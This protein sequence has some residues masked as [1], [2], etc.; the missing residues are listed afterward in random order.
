MNLADFGL[1]PVGSSSSTS[2]ISR[3][4]GRIDLGALGLAPVES[5][6]DVFGRETAIAP[7][8]VPGPSSTVGDWSSG[9][10]G[11]SIPQFNEPL[12]P[13][14]PSAWQQA[15]QNTG[16]QFN[17]DPASPEAAGL[18]PSSPGVWRAP[19]EIQNQD[20]EGLSSQELALID[21]FS[22][23]PEN[24][25]GIEAL[26][27]DEQKEF[28][29][30]LIEDPES[31]RNFA[32]GLREDI[33][34]AAKKRLREFAKKQN[35]VV[36]DHRVRVSDPA[37]LSPSDWIDYNSKLPYPITADLAG[38]PEQFARLKKLNELATGDPYL[39][40]PLE[41]RDSR[42]RE[43]EAERKAMQSAGVNDP[44]QWLIQQDAAQRPAL[45][46]RMAGSLL[47]G[48]KESIGQTYLG[49]KDLMGEM[50]QGSAKALGLPEEPDYLDSGSRWKQVG[51]QQ[52]WDAAVRDEAAKKGVLGQRATRLAETG[53]EAVGRMLPG[54]ALGMAAGSAAA[55]AGAG[56]EATS[57][58]TNAATWAAIAGDVGT[59][60]YMNARANGRPVDQA[61]V[62]GTLAAGIE[63]VTE[64][65]GAK[66]AG[67]F[68][69]TT[70]EEAVG[71]AMTSA[72]A[73]S[74]MELAR[75]LMTG[76]VSEGGEEVAAD[77][78]NA[79][80]ANATGSQA[81]KLSIDGLTDTFLVGAFAAGALHIPRVAQFVIEQAKKPHPETDAQ[82][83]A[84]S[85][86]ALI[87]SNL[88]NFSKL[89]D[90]E[91]TS[92][93][94]LEEFNRRRNEILRGKP[95]GWQTRQEFKARGPSDRPSKV[96]VVSK[97][98]APG[99]QEI[100]RDFYSNPQNAVTWARENPD[101]AAKLAASKNYTPQAFQEADPDLPFF[102]GE[103][104][105]SIRKQFRDVVKEY[106]GD[107]AKRAVYDDWS[108]NGPLKWRKLEGTDAAVHPSVKKFSTAA[109]EFY[110][111]QPPAA[112]PG[113][114]FGKKAEQQTIGFPEDEAKAPE[115][116]PE[117]ASPPPSLPEEQQ[118]PSDD[119]HILLGREFGKSLIEGRG[120]SNINDARKQASEFLG[121]RVKPGTPDAKAVDEAVEA[122]TVIAARKII[123][124][125]AGNRE[126]TYDKL[127]DLY[128]RQPRLAVQ[129]STS[130]TNQA[131]STPAPLAYLAHL[132]ADPSGDHFVYDSSAGNGMLLA[133]TDVSKARANEIDP[134]R[135]SVIASQGI[136]VNVGDAMEHVPADLPDR[137]IINPP[138]GAVMGE[139]RLPKSWTVGTYKTESIDH[140][141]TLKT[142]ESMKDDGKAVI[143]IGSKG[144]QT[145]KPKDDA[146][147][148]FAYSSH[149]GFYDRLYDNYNVVD[150]FTVSGDLYARQGAKFP[151]DVIV[152][153]GKGQSA[154]PK[155]WQFKK[156]GIP[157]LLSSWGE[158]GDHV[159]ARVGAGAEPGS[160]SQRPGKADD[161]GLP[162]PPF[163]KNR[164]PGGGRGGRGGGRPGDNQN[165]VGGKTRG[166]PGDNKPGST[167]G[168]DGG[169]GDNQQPSGDKVSGDGGTGGSRRPGE[170][171]PSDL[172]DDG[173]VDLDSLSEDEIAKKLLELMGGGDA[174]PP[175]LAPPPPPKSPPSKFPPQPPKPPESSP[176]PRKGDKAREELSEAWD[177]FKDAL[178][179][180]GL[181][182]VA[183][184]VPPKLAAASAKLAAKALKA[185]I[186]T[187]SD[188]LEDAVKSLGMATV[189]KVVGPLEQAWQAAGLLTGGKTDKP[190]NATAILDALEKK[191]SQPSEQPAVG[192][193]ETEF[194]VSYVPRS[195]AGVIGTLSPVNQA[196]SIGKALDL[197]I[198][199]VGELDKYVADELGMK[200][201]DV[202]GTEGK[203]GV[204]SAEQVDALALTI[205]NFKRGDATIVADQ[206]GVGKGRVIAGLFAF[207]KRQG[208]IPI[209]VTEK[210]NL[211]AD[212]MR[213]LTDIGLNSKN[214]LFEPLITNEMDSAVARI[215]LH[216][217]AEELGERIY[218]LSGEALYKEFVEGRKT[219]KKNSGQMVG[220]K[221]TYDAIFTT[222]SQ[223]RPV[224]GKLSWRNG[225]IGAMLPHAFLVLDESHN[226]G[227]NAS[228]DA[229]G[230]GTKPREDKS[231]I[232]T[233]DILRGLVARAQG[234]VYSS[235]TFAKRAGMLDLYS[236]AG[237]LDAETLERI[238]SR[239]GVPLQ[240][241]L[242]EMW[243]EAGLL[244]RRE[245]S[246]KGV[247]LKSSVLD[248]DLDAVNKAASIYRAI[249]ALSS[250]VQE[251]LPEIRAGY[252]GEGGD[253]GTDN[254]TGIKGVDS[255]EFSSILHNLNSQFLF[256]LKVDAVADEA[257]ASI[258][259]GESPVIAVDET[260]ETALNRYATKTHASH[261]QKIDFSIK[262][263]F[264]RY[265]ERSR[266]IQ[267]KTDRDGP[268]GPNRVRLTDEELGP[269]GVAAFEAA[270]RLIKEFDAD[271]PASPIDW[272]R[273]R[274][275]KAGYKVAEI[276]GR[277]SMID[278]SGGDK[279]SGT[280]VERPASELGTS[281]K[282][283]SVLG[284]NNGDIDVL[285]L[286]RSGSTGLSIHASVK[287]NNKRKR[288]M[289]IAQPAK[290]IDEFMQMLG[291]VHRTGQVLPPK[292]SLFLTTAPG[293]NRMS[294]VLVRKL[295]SLNAN[296]TASAKGSVGFD[297]P[298]I[299]NE[300][301][302]DVVAD[303]GIA[304]IHLNADMAHPIRFTQGGD[305]ITKDLST[306]LTGRLVFL[307][308]EIQR[309]FWET[310]AD[311]FR[312]RIELLNSQNANPLVAQ[313]L[314]LEA[315][316]RARVEISKGGDASSPNP[317]HQPA[318]LEEVDA[319]RLSK[320]M[321]SKQVREA[322]GEFYGLES[323]DPS[324][325]AKAIEWADREIDDLE[326]KKE[327]WAAKK[328]EAIENDFK[329]EIDAI[330][331]KK[332]NWPE[333]EDKASTKRES[334]I[335]S[336]HGAAEENF[337]A[338]SQ[339]L[340][341]FH[342]GRT[343]T[344][345]Y[346]EQAVPGVV[347]SV[348]RATGD[349]P[350]A[351]GQ[352]TF[353]IAMS[354]VVRTLRVSASQ[355]LRLGLQGQAPVRGS[356]FMGDLDVFDA[357]D[358]QSREKRYIGTGNIVA[359]MD[360]LDGAHGRISFFTDS[361]GE[362]R[363]GIVLP[364][365][366]D[367]KKFAEA[368]PVVFE[369]A[370]DVL[371]F[372]EAGGQ[373][374]T[375]DGKLLILKVGGQLVVRAP[376]SKSR[377]RQ[378][379]A[380]PGIMQAASPDEFTELSQRWELTVGE[381]RRQL[382]VLEAIQEISSIITEG[383]KDIARR[384]GLDK[385]P[386]FSSG[387]ESAMTAKPGASFAKGKSS[388]KAGT[389]VAP[390]PQLPSSQ[391]QS[392]AKKS[393][394]I[395][396]QDIVTTLQR[397]F[398][399]PIRAGF[400]AVKKVKGQ[401]VLGLY[402][403]LYEVARIRESNLFELGTVTHET[404]HHIDN[405]TKTTPRSGAGSM[406]AKIPPSVRAEI[407]ALDYNAPQQMRPH[408]GWAEFIRMYLTDH[409]RVGPVSTQRQGPLPP[410][411]V[412]WFETDWAAAHP[413]E[414]RKLQKAREYIRQ[415][416]DQDVLQ[417][418]SAAIAKPRTD[419]EWAGR[420]AAM[421]DDKK[422]AAMYEGYDDTQ[423][424]KVLDKFADES[425]NTRQNIRDFYRVN[426]ST[427]VANATDA[428]EHGVFDVETGR[429]IGK[430][431]W[432][433]ILKATTDMQDIGNAVAYA[434]ARHTLF[435]EQKRPEYN[436]AFAGGGDAY[437]SVKLA[438]EY[439][440]MLTKDQVQ[441]YDEVADAISDFAH[442]LDA[443]RVRAG[444][445]SA[446]DYSNAIRFY[447]PGGY[448][449]LGRMADSKKLQKL[450]R[451]G[452]IFNA[453]KAFPGRSREGSGRPVRDAFDQLIEQAVVAYQH[454]HNARLARVIVERLDPQFG[455]ANGAGFFLA[456]FPHDTKITQLAVKDVL[457]QLV[458]QGWVSRTTANAAII[459]GMLE[460]KVAG[461][462]GVNS[463]NFI[464]GLLRLP[465]NASDMQIIRAAK[466]AGVPDILSVLRRFRP[467]WSPIPGKR[468]VQYVDRKTGEQKRY[469]ILNERL[470]AVVTGMNSLDFGVFYGALKFSQYLNKWFSLGAIGLSTQ[471]QSRNIVRDLQD[472]AAQSKHYHPPKA[473]A[474]SMEMFWRYLWH[475]LTTSLGSSPS[476]KYAA[477]FELYNSRGG[478]LNSILKQEQ[479]SRI[480]HARRRLARGFREKAL[481][482]IRHPLETLDMLVD[483]PVDFFSISDVP[484]RLSEADAS[485]R[486]AGYEPVAGTTKW[487]NI[488]TGVESPQLPE[489]VIVQ[490]MADALDS[491]MD[492]KRAGRTARAVNALVPLTAASI[493]GT[494]RRI[495]NLAV[496]ASAV[497]KLKR[498]EKLTQV[499]KTQLA[500]YAA[501]A[502]A[503]FAIGLSYG[504]TGGKDDHREEEDAYRKYN[505]LTTGDDGETT[506]AL[507]KSYQFAPFFALGEWLAG[508]MEAK[509]AV[510]QEIQNDLPLGGGW[511]RAVGETFI[512]NW[513][514]FRGRPVEHQTTG[515]KELRYDAY[516]TRAAKAIGNYTGRYLGV[517]PQQV[518]HFLGAA[519]GGA[520]R[521]YAESW[522]AWQEDRLSLRQVPLVSGLYVGQV[523]RRS[524]NEFFAEYSAADDNRKRYN[525][526][527]DVADS[528]GDAKLAEDLREKADGYA[529]RRRELNNY[530]KMIDAIT[531][532]EVEGNR[533]GK[534]TFD[535]QKYVVGLAR[536]AIGKPKLE[537]F[538]SPLDD[539]ELP[540]DLRPV[541]REQVDRH[542]N[543]ALL[544]LGRPT[545]EESRDGRS[546]DDRREDWQ[547]MIEA[548]TDFLRRHKDHPIVQEA[549]RDAQQSSGYKAMRKAAALAES[550]T[551]RKISRWTGK[552]WTKGET[553][554]Q[555]EKRKESRAWDLERRKRAR[556]FLE[557]LSAGEG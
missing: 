473:I 299:I 366:F 376:G 526:D 84:K 163:G 530:R 117:P 356:E 108:T 346:G 11:V 183:G 94:F 303:W 203:P 328:V 128:E 533:F 148:A 471:F 73:K 296:V 246:Y 556:D 109:G 394:P 291:R 441:R 105:A 275:S 310:V 339:A 213:D 538:P 114:P 359:A 161:G 402:S 375:T 349:N 461:V 93:D 385:A 467:D 30:W 353:A 29:R 390:T 400:L 306:K 449:P 95:I 479:G 129:T 436:T 431:L 548:S 401:K 545:V 154:R 372:L 555:F 234:V 9:G 241:A 432:P 252:I 82:K 104:A 16:W 208:M 460:K 179:D 18:Y 421:L 316:T 119:E 411:A 520:F 62:D 205:R 468:I 209:F 121:R 242:S 14:A 287:F 370:K 86:D 444:S 290:N 396:A 61:I 442:E 66:V 326:K 523:G 347:V 106:V 69:A 47:K 5:S 263:L 138:F 83:A 25:P 228:V 262:E 134:R 153:D 239:G 37:K 367:P 453:G 452:S 136:D 315:K 500:N 455:G 31:A 354:D 298:D 165:G 229:A 345:T 244:I 118:I 168:S 42:K 497:A 495:E 36:D 211:F 380:D 191:A 297:V 57:Q 144:F 133:A 365:K 535:Y 466:A 532:Q 478:R 434:H 125:N 475:Q 102:A 274:L 237:G 8:Q 393:K 336:V 101:A 557:S 236:R 429:R 506:W 147:R 448:F 433:K 79:M 231:K 413:V 182:S 110:R 543:S 465:A 52:A 46:G 285:I 351:R 107:E 440:A 120:Y 268:D 170:P 550:G 201:S 321:S 250:R 220:K 510:A 320:P 348:T 525:A 314:P 260:L 199:E 536:E 443:M 185:G 41:Q 462:V 470:Y 145:G 140:A 546:L 415:F 388:A 222:Y 487:R 122:G 132:L 89:L 70:A 80:R 304:N 15:M 76:L 529:L 279:N 68:G 334:R 98:A 99:E 257:I 517:S 7:T 305:V 524:W 332:P 65:L 10:D 527:A 484:A 270:E 58:A 491:T 463:R 377:N 214:K 151:V 542:I 489:R 539:P 293:E 355:M 493:R 224:Q 451:A 301:G 124:D 152:V 481:A 164:K 63:L 198:E 522:D 265:L 329:K 143:I 423:P 192:D 173:A 181:L 283:K 1:V 447:G 391:Q 511:I 373:A 409:K 123:R 446:E 397:M 264:L 135:A 197:L 27:P 159:F 507:P 175:P 155:P 382:A 496:A 324:L 313:T 322:V 87:R 81:D 266:E 501:T 288:H 169:R 318:Y 439:V 35:S 521:R 458:E 160:R 21:S 403:Y 194:Q 360:A 544:S 307:P 156:G 406:W 251:V 534:R 417:R 277:H 294:A 490:A 74:K 392:K 171:G 221:K 416:D 364:H 255:K 258:K 256:A 112:K 174:A 115:T 78:L 337:S 387:D 381:P 281:G 437:E 142:L 340:L 456:P 445:L 516:T 219:Y 26:T 327:A 97:E 216:S 230:K 259:R 90:I 476:G 331:R 189:R 424:F 537:S 464:T 137:V 518:D 419:L 540:E 202:M 53:T 280:L 363:R 477:V 323:D 17:Y 374:K 312:N 139:N 459:L 75:E 503:T 232:K 254:A 56:A 150:H 405:I 531:R 338:V 28:R 368:R 551:K 157:A 49:A 414:F 4:K 96:R 528:Q 407:S 553:T 55:G 311:S 276:T 282:I 60:E 483:I 50:A 454:A 195:K 289:I 494:G 24:P 410:N 379:V 384:L 146:S 418:L 249:Q 502:A 85:A 541:V 77:I 438:R 172:A 480:R 215:D 308:V 292:Y 509:E 45:P 116:K 162:G 188:F 113:A 149:K 482:A 223:L 317:F 196:A 67:R 141:I 43:I 271:V 267:V 505:S 371:V 352:W 20:P 34:D 193:A 218:D 378:Y 309:E 190:A 39:D 178:K 184:G 206:T 225:E 210:P 200:L 554:E 273:Y 131:Y 248:V 362:V 469:E 398:D 302:D 450:T 3:R 111:I 344:I 186:L 512:A 59:S 167:G 386:S 278:Y 38:D 383:D 335:R 514:Y 284:F 100:Y 72:A 227:A 247:E 233:A 54:I 240:Q 300:V 420:M 286:N 430:G 176:P 472:Y 399:L 6:S 13:S 408:E 428:L 425:G 243:S 474:K 158:L 238:S 361:T 457:D 519:T 177:E 126:G 486:A 325:R 226:A 91:P 498:G 103:G 32:A 488:R 19:S 212:I 204:F 343:V 330:D 395:S 71:R 253:A 333:L 342:P 389:N 552:S 64:W 127:I 435:M 515:P 412:Q 485:I 48:T 492:H 88:R 40:T 547:V 245:R 358:S 51:T 22:Q 235:A 12:S 499:E 319:R 341:A 513:D 33:R 44:A 166:G 504:L 130:I 272:I 217:Q 350:I 92:P 269:V 549:I 404:A 508:S 427:A 357:N 369:T 295:S 426:R 23:A 180:T 261:G 422:E 187:F 207:A 2:S